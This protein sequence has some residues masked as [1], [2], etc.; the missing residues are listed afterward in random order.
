[1]SLKKTPGAQ[2][3]SANANSKSVRKIKP[4]ASTK[5][6]YLD[7]AR[8]DLMHCIADGLFRPMQKGQQATSKLDLHYK[9]NTGYT[10]WWRN[11]QPLSITDQSVFLAIHRLLAEKDRAKVVP[12]TSADSNERSLMNYL[13]LRG[14][15]SDSTTLMLETSL[16]EIARTIG[17]TDG[18]E[19]LK[20]LLECIVR[21]SSVTCSVYDND[22]PSK[23]FWQANLFSH[24]A[25]DKGRIFIAVNPML[26]KALLVQRNA[27][28]DMQN[29]RALNS[30]AAKRLHFWL[31]G[32]ANEGVVKKIELDKLVLHVWGD[33][34]EGD[35]LRNRRRILRK[36]ISEIAALPGWM[37]EEKEHQ[38]VFVCKPVFQ[39]NS[40][41]NDIVDAQSDDAEEDGAEVPS[42]TEAE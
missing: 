14:Q 29:Q 21:L 28:V 32:W 13:Q 22:D 31:S 11:F 34:P 24:L 1:M 2:H 7:H 41:P 19:N 40:N 18:G 30:D 35:V 9:M 38:M 39:G 20:S 8:L 10:L 5:V 17:M 12:T 6:M 37:C 25:M 4:L 42:S 36:A 23:S 27:Y 16:S 26:S 33:E 15:A 3:A